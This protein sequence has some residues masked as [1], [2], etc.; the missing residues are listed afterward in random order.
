MPARSRPWWLKATGQGVL[1]ALPGAPALD[2]WLRRRRG[3]ELDPDYV[4][5]KWVHVRSHLRALGAREGRPLP[6]VTV[7]ELGTGWYP[8]VA[9]G[10]AL[11]GARVVSVDT[12]AH[13]DGD[14]IALTL[15]RV[16]RL[17]DDGAVRVPE[18]AALDRARELVAAGGPVPPRALQEVG[19][20]SH[21]ADARDLS[22]IPAARGAAL[23]VSNNTLEHIPREVLGG[24][25]TEFH[26]VG[27]AEARMSHYVD[28]ADHYAGFDPAAGDFHFLTLGPTAW[29]LANNRLGYQNRLRI[30]DYRDLH[31]RAGWAIEA[32]RLTRR[33][34]TELHGLR[35]VEPFASTPA[36]DLLV[37]KAHLTSARAPGVG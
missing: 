34:P 10:M 21:L 18:G 35:L 5:G 9:L 6:D 37:V 8:V 17:V 24:I 33:D 2:D 26:R 19:V 15:R 20:G 29:R 22:G 11:H 1:A 16:L 30:S 23:M 31:A 3:A 32:E 28:L 27:G 14:R 25:L 13:L 12:R 36:D 7:V 4:L